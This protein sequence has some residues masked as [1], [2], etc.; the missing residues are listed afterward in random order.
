MKN[1]VKK[2]LAVLLCAVVIFSFAACSAKENGETSVSASDTANGEQLKIGIIQY[3][4]NPSLDN[5]S[6]GIVNALEKSNLN[7]KIDRQIGSDSTADSDCA[8]YAK[9]MVAQKYDMIFAIATPAAKATYAATEGTDIPVIFCAVSD[10]VGAK[11]VE[12]NEVPGDLCTGTSDKLDLDAQ[13]DLIQSMQ[14]DV[15]SIGILYTTSES[16]SISQLSIL[17]DICAKRNIEVV[18]SGI[19]NDADIPA[20]ASAL[21]AKVD[22][23]NNFTDNKVVINLPVVIDAAN[24]AKIPVYGSEV[25]QLKSGC[26]AA[27]SIDYVSLGEVTGQMGLDVL[28]GADITKM[29]VK[30]ISDTTPVVNPDVLASLGIELPKAYSNAETVKTEAK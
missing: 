3:S 13:V 16:N 29:A 11:L 24:D 8:S 12:S 4:S 1:S 27:V 5:C 2:I 21:A 10:P 17:K 20:A 23:I 6:Q 22:C 14:P 26:L 18:P 19:Q 25:E 9:T 30:A 7:I 15:K 28:G